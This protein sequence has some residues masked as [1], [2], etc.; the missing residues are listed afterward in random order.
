MKAR[1]ED[2]DQLRSLES[3]L[4][5]LP[6][7][8]TLATRG[9]KLIGRSPVIRV[10]PQKESSPSFSRGRGS[11]HS[12]CGSISSTM[13]SSSPWDFY[14]APTPSTCRTSAFSVSSSASSSYCPPSQSNSIVQ[15]SPQR[16]GVSRS[17]SSASSESR[18]PTP[19]SLRGFKRKEEVL[20]MLIF[21]DLVIV[22]G[23]SEKVGLFT[24]K[25]KEKTWRVLPEMD[26]GVGKVAEVRDWSGYQGKWRA[27]PFNQLP[28]LMGDHRP[29]KL[30]YR[31]SPSNWSFTTSPP[32]THIHCFHLGSLS[33]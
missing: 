16:P 29:F 2:F 25:K 24:G 17:P 20:T 11:L 27:H 26:G 9:R 6:E 23:E 10:P 3:R 21:N 31:D 18:P 33:R 15:T 30:V 14:R 28:R 4:C 19:S 32:R 8:F 12:S 5:G 13:S 22:A 7:G 1:E